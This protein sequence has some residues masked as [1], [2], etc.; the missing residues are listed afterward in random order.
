MT[1]P[2][3]GAE[4]IAALR[5]RRAAQGLEEVRGIYAPKPLHAT[6]KAYARKLLVPKPAK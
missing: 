6:I 4:R 3:T 2:A 5:A 1:K